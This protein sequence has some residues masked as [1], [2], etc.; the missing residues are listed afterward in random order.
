MVVCLPA[1]SQRSAT[2]APARPVRS[3]LAGARSGTPVAGA[4]PCGRPFRRRGPGTARQG[5]GRPPRPARAREDVPMSMPARRPDPSTQQALSL[6]SAGEESTDS[7]AAGAADQPPV[8]AERTLTPAA[9]ADLPAPSV[10]GSSVESPVTAAPQADM[11]AP[12]TEPGRV[13][14]LAAPPR[15]VAAPPRPGRGGLGWGW[16][17][18][19]PSASAATPAT[20][21]AAAP[22]GR[23]PWPG[24]ACAPCRSWP[25]WTLTAR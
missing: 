12:A 21:T 14:V 24:R 19:P 9:D 11:L 22:A 1:S 8:T 7:T 20:G 17:V 23:W 15:P 25:A 6:W 3:S 13:A 5:T 16:G 18:A 4:T 10:G 2:P